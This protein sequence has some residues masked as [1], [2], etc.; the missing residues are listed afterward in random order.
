[1]SYEVW[2]KDNYGRHEILSVLNTKG[3]PENLWETPEEALAAAKRY[4]HDKNRNNPLTFDEQKR[5]STHVVAE[6]AEGGIYAG[7]LIMGKHKVITAAGEQLMPTGTQFQFYLGETPD[8]TAWYLD[9]AR[10]R[11]VTDLDNYLVTEKTIVF[12]KKQK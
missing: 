9:D 1:M 8:R 12:V 10:R 6:L 2:A 5:A 7:N 4:V 11:A 3:K